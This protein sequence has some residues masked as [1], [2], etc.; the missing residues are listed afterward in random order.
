MYKAAIYESERGWGTKL[1]EERIFPTKEER[2]KFVKEFNDDVK[3]NEVYIP[4]IYFY[5]ECVN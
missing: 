5:A 3:T 4:D 1:M 2:D